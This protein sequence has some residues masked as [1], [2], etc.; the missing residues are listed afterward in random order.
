MQL[1]KQVPL[2][3]QFGGMVIIVIVEIEGLEGGLGGATGEQHVPRTSQGQSGKQVQFPK[4][5]QGSAGGGRKP[6][7]YA[8]QL[9]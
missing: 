1:G 9:L 6:K 2:S 7:V 3:K 5:T 4:K 8:V